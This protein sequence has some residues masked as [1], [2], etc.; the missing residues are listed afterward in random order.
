M[1]G[2]ILFSRLVG[3][4]RRA[5][6]F[7]TPYI[8]GPE[9]RSQLERALRI[10]E[11]DFLQSPAALLFPPE[12]HFAESQKELALFWAEYIRQGE[13]ASLGESAA[14]P[15]CSA[16]SLP[17]P[18]Q[19]GRGGAGACGNAF[20]HQGRAGSKEQARLDERLRIRRERRVMGLD[21]TEEP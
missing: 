21:E 11:E 3:P 16:R 14:I 12:R 15:G 7:T 9:A 20:P 5:I 6:F 18:R 17:P 4:P 1:P 13:K 10:Q 19:Y 2:E 8:F